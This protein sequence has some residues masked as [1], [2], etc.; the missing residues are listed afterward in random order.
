MHKRDYREKSVLRAII[1]AVLILALVVTL[2][3]YGLNSASTTVDSEGLRIAADSVRRAAVTCY[4][5]EGRYPSSY[6]YLTEN[7]GLA[8]DDSRY[9]VHYEA[10]AS[11]LM[12]SIT[13]VRR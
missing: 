1:P 8:I 6:E 10:F 7:Y 13:V 4:S 3:V 9:I 5:V 2:V 11:N 12:P